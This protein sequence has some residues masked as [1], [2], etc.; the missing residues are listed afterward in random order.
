MFAHPYG[1]ER[2]LGGVAG[3]GA[4]QTPQPRGRVHK[5]PP[6]HPLVKRILLRTQPDEAVEGWIVPNLLAEDLHGTLAGIKLSG[7]QL[8]KSGLARAVG[9]EQAGDAGGDPDRELVDPDVVAR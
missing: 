4:A 5:V 3:V 9:T 2:T 6:G 8:E 1:I 7:R